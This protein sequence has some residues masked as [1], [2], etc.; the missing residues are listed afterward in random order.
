MS[1]EDVYARA[2]MDKA[3]DV[4]PARLFPPNPTKAFT[5]RVCW[6]TVNVGGKLSA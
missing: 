5:R 2:Q 6:N 4:F 3:L 1:G